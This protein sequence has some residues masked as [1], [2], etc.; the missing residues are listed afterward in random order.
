MIVRVYK[1]K[2]S[3]LM[4]IY[5][6]LNVYF[7]KRVEGERLNLISV[8]KDVCECDDYVHSKQMEI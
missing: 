5:Q 4:E 2:G 6:S 1:I 8:T 7:Q 3:R